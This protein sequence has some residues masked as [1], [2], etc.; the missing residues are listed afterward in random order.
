[1]QERERK[2]T[3]SD[4]PW[5]AGLCTR[6][7]VSTSSGRCPNTTS[8]VTL[9]SKEEAG[10][11]R[12]SG[13]CRALCPHVAVPTLKQLVPNFLWG[14]L[15]QT[16]RVWQRRGL[17]THLDESEW[18]WIS[19]LS[20]ASKK[21]GKLTHMGKPWCPLPPSTSSPP[22][23]SPLTSLHL[24]VPL[25]IPLSLADPLEP[26]QL[27][28]PLPQSLSSC[29]CSCCV[30]PHF[31]NEGCS[32]GSFVSIHWNSQVEKA[33]GYHSCP[34]HTLP[35]PDSIL[36]IISSHK[37]TH[38]ISG[39]TRSHLWNEL[40]ARLRQSELPCRF[41]RLLRPLDLG[42]RGRTW[43]ALTRDHSSLNKTS[44]HRMD[45]IHYPNI[46]FSKILL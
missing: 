27:A 44:S 34:A 36:Q 16:P 20:S 32:K 10:A 35:Y 9:L 42:L 23:S 24:P 12:G 18:D 17:E 41:L 14:R 2:S 46:C 1:M 40:L 4:L 29:R 22:A 11:Q 30:H 7:L 13:T 3:F 45:R 38:W 33:N 6:W 8:K 43:P 37:I 31:A 19:S 39:G 21:P 26:L 5:G 25:T 15:E 28:G